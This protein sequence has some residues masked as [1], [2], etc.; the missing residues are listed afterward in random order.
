[1]SFEFLGG[2]FDSQVMRIYV[3]LKK[4]QFSCMWNT[5]SLMVMEFY[6][7]A[8]FELETI[9]TRPCWHHIYWDKRND[10]RLARLEPWSLAFGSYTNPLRHRRYLSAVENICIK[11][12]T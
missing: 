8:H 12:L 7:C 1:M 11:F 3:K 10:D 2:W 9:F 5:Y 6:Y 4:S